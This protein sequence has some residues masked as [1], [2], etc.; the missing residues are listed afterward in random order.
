MIEVVSLNRDTLPHELEIII[1]ILI[2][3]AIVQ[4]FFSSQN[5]Y[6]MYIIMHTMCA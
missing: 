5:D 2:S 3:A 4:C 6:C 1:I